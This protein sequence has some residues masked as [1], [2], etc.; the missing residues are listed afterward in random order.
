MEKEENH[1]NE[2]ND[3]VILCVFIQIEGSYFIQWAQA[4]IILISRGQTPLSLSYNWL[5]S[6]MLMLD[7]AKTYKKNWNLDKQID[8]SSLS[9]DS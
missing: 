3:L 1:F 8:A 9:G 6:E 4:H 5:E 7:K 2:L